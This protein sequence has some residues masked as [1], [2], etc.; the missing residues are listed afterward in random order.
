MNLR[1]EA[2]DRG[3]TKRARYFTQQRVAERLHLS[4]GAYTAYEKNREPPYFRRQEIAKAF[5]LDPEYFE[6]AHAEQDATLQ[7][8]R[9]ELAGTRAEVARLAERV[10]EVYRVL[11]RSR[12]EEHP[13]EP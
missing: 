13:S 3:D 1:K 4:L 8:L 2:L 5:D 10:E 9:E 7:G 12:R 6:I 11:S